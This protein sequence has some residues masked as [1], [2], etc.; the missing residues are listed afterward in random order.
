ME[1]IEKVDR[2]IKRTR[3]F[4]KEAL[5]KLM[6]EK[7]YSSISIQDIT[8]YANINRS[9]FYYHYMDKE[10]LLQVSMDEMIAKAIVDVSTK[11]ASND[12][13]K[14][15]YND[16]DP[17]PFFIRM[18]E[19]IQSNAPFY[20]VMLEEAPTFR[21][22]ITEAIKQQY[23]ESIALMQPDERQLIVSKQM[24]ATFVSGAY[25]S[26]IIQWLE[27]NLADSVT[28]M[29]EQLSKIMMLGPHRV[30]GLI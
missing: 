29:A 15:T 24:L 14:A 27:N 6:S 10:D 23:M 19:H 4:I 21:R 2:R 12:D 17:V 8:E 22:R 28:E 5:I 11:Q 7:S 20:R 25:I 16:Y 9:T 30:S 1:S 26:I 18:F 13:S 3:Q